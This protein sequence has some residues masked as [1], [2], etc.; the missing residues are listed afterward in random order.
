MAEY[1]DKR[2]VFYQNLIDAGCKK[3]CI[4]QYAVLYENKENQ[5]LIRQ[6]SLYRKSLLDSLHQVQSK[7]DCLDYLLYN[8]ENEKFKEEDY[9]L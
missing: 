9:D 4:G 8:L 6:L 5:K 3:Q 7:I 2:T 1:N